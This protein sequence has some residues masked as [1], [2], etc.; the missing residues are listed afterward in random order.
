VRPPSLYKYFP[1][2]HAVYDALFLRGSHE[3]LAVLR[4]A[5]AQAAPGLGCLTHGL[6]ASGRWSLDNRALAELLF[7]RP[8]PSFTPSAEAFAVAEEMVE[9]QR[10]ALA[11]AVDAGELGPE[12]RSGDAIYVVAILIA[13]VLSQA[14]ANEPDVAWGEG[15]FSSQFPRL[16]KLL[17]AAF[18]PTRQAP[19]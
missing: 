7:M 2:L 10:G 4:A 5:M 8:V 1:S 17:P 12:A 9:L 13:G 6:E 16:M 15:R 14:I 19:A 18:P 11:D 3:H